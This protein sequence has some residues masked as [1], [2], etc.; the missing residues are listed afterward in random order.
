MGN[1]VTTIALVTGA[2]KGIG[3]ETARQLAAKGITDREA[4]ADL[5]VDELMELTEMPE[6]R[7]KDLIMK[8]RAHWF[9]NEAAGQ[10]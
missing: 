6:D 3:L 9:A 1:T 5:G 2:N 7:A 4:L 8:A 10:E